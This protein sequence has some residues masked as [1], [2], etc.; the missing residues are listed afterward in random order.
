M[1]IRVLGPLSAEVDGDSIV[2]TASKPRQILALLALHPGQVMPVPT[3]M[4]EIWGH[5]LPLSAPTT[6]Q[7]YV[8]QLRRRLGTAMGAGRPGGSLPL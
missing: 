7:T 5:E 6:L 1:K 3:L 2:P 4:E 8:L